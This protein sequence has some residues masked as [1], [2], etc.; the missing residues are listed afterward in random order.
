[1][2]RVVDRLADRRLLVTDPVGEDSF[3]VEVAHEALIRHWPRLQGWLAKDL[4]ALLGR[5]QLGYAAR[6]WDRNGR[7][8]D[9]LLHRGRRLDEALRLCRASAGFL[10]AL[11]QQ[12]LDAC[13]SLRRH[14][15]RRAR[16][17]AVAALAAALTVV[18]LLALTIVTVQRNNIFF[19][20][21]ESRP[22]H[23]LIARQGVPL[24]QFLPAPL[25]G[26]TLYDT[27][28][29]VDD[30]TPEKRASLDR[31]RA[32]PG[33]DTVGAPATAALLDHLA[34]YSKV[35]WQAY[36]GD[37]KAA[38]QT[39]RDQPLSK[40][41]DRAWVD[42][43]AFAPG[44]AIDPLLDALN[45]RRIEVRVDAMDSLARLGRGDV[46]RIAP[47]LAPQL[48][49]T[50]KNVQW[51]AAR[52]L[53]ELGAAG[54]P[55][56]VPS[57]V[58]YMLFD[59][60]GSYFP[61]TR[62]LGRRTGWWEFSGRRRL[63]DTLLRLGT[64]ARAIDLL[65]PRLREGDAEERQKAAGA[66]SH[67]GALQPEKVV[68]ALLPL[69]ADSVLADAL[70][71]GKP[72]GATPGQTETVS[73]LGVIG[74]A[75][76]AAVI[77]L[78]LTGLDS[79]NP[80]VRRN[81]LQILGKIGR[82]R[83]KA[84]IER[85]LPLLGATDP[86]LPALAARTWGVSG[87]P[88]GQGPLLVACAFFPGS[89]GDPNVR[90]EAVRALGR[91]GVPDGRLI[92]PLRALV[93]EAGGS[94][95]G[96]DPGAGPEYS[97]KAEAAWALGQVARQAK[98]TVLPDL[99]RLLSD[100]DPHVRADAAWSIG[101]LK[102]DTAEVARHLVPLLA[103]KEYDVRDQAAKALQNL[104]P[105]VVGRLAPQ[106]I[107]MLEQR[108]DADAKKDDRAR[109]VAQVLAVLDASQAKTA[110]PVLLERLRA[111][112]LIVDRPEIIRALGKL[113]TA[114]PR[115]VAPVLWRFLR[116]AEQWWQGDSLI[117]AEVREV[118]IDA[119]AALAKADREFV[120]T[121]ALRLLKEEGEAGSRA[122]LLRLLGRLAGQSPPEDRTIE[123]LEQRLADAEGE[124]RRA[125][126]EA[127]GLCLLSR[128]RNDRDQS[129][130]AARLVEL[131]SGDRSQKN[132]QYR[133]AVIYGLA[134]WLNAGL[135]EGEV[136]SDSAD[137]ARKQVER[138]PRAVT[139]HGPL[140][141]KLEEL[142]DNEPR[143]WLRAAACEVWA[144]ARRQRF[145][146][147]DDFGQ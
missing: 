128:I 125:A 115:M 95:P 64:G 106:L 114:N 101:Q 107:T 147:R 15:L 82:Q 138:V 89:T 78:L 112:R 35:R 46:G 62:V 51:H 20:T 72:G 11:D 123:E 48:A 8:D 70:D 126:V 84:V 3:T 41:W 133:R 59:S 121:E 6:D 69:L 109:R 118:A 104:G 17:T 119:L 74:E 13:V 116:N 76:P 108:Q 135:P 30:L 26:A 58:E 55:D 42:L 57:F 66:L 92:E 124:V 22:P 19:W 2:R 21:D 45:D 143:L 139:E 9:D 54:P 83:D 34:P 40:E 68:S 56:I 137:A 1:V 146:P 136:A 53:G 18:V 63:A 81:T 4:P 98:G 100:D 12:Y 145:P 5:E 117:S 10:N 33:K 80:I 39:L 14:W 79:P 140:L 142:R 130:A 110:V 132:A 49:D 43:N 29:T 141:R 36:A 86:S 113:G 73:A 111:E 16:R 127:L 91:I 23:P 38:L 47:H 7:K 144:S 24:L 75:K 94:R 120:E 134:T 97:L 44:A 37:W 32:S 77:P 67:L 102:P 99:V 61:Y 122:A 85:I 105:T 52:A 131:L 50:D 65:L 88:S 25:D 96:A 28:L 103:D 71:Q 93:N 31:L 60:S 27:G 87:C 129:N 90:L